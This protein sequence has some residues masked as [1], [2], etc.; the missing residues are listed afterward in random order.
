VT[1]TKVPSADELARAALQTE[2]ND[3]RARVLAKLHAM[4][5]HEV[6]SLAVEFVSSSVVAER[7]LGLDILAQLGFEEQRG[8]GRWPFYDS[9]LP[10]LRVCLAASEK[11]VVAAAAYAFLHLGVQDVLPDLIAL[12]EHPDGGCREAVV[13][14]LGTSNDVAATDCLLRLMSDAEPSVRNW[15]SFAVAQSGR[16]DALVRDALAA[17]VRDADEEVRIEAL[18]GLARRRDPRCVPALVDE[19]SGDVLSSLA[20]EAAAAIGDPALSPLLERW[21]EAI[22]A[23]DEFAPALV[24]ALEAT[25]IH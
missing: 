17:S 20:I 1:T 16:D 11:E 12:T 22:D 5:S 15:A 3:E 25:S 18:L 10:L 6:F 7:R 23:D 14:A 8:T 13:C 24:A 2:D 19:L 21:M 9:S 4:G